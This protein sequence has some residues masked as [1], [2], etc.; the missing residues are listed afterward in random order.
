MS[1]FVRIEGFDPEDLADADAHDLADRLFADIHEDYPDLYDDLA[2]VIPIL[3]EDEHARLVEVSN[4]ERPTDRDKAIADRRAPLPDGGTR[5]VTDEPWEPWCDW[6]QRVFGADGPDWTVETDVVTGWFCSED[7][8]DSWDDDDEYTP[9]RVGEPEIATDGGTDLAT[10]EFTV[11]DDGSSIVYGPW[12]DEEWMLAVSTEDGERVRL[13]LGEAA[14]YE[15]WTEVHH[16]PWPR[17]DEPR[18][19]LSREIVEKVNGMDEDQLREVLE[20]VDKVGGG[21]R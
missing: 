21:E 7:C 3:N 18:G 16:T 13:L 5:S 6:C 20:T 15:L 2:G 1:V 4:I 17:K 12:D 10:H 11:R 8:A 19:T 14:M 9:E